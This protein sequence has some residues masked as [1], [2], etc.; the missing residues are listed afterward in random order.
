MADTVTLSG[1]GYPDVNGLYSYSYE[2]DGYPAYIK[3]DFFI[4][5]KT[6]NGPYSFTPNYYIGVIITTDDG[7]AIPVVRY[8]YRNDTIDFSGTWVALTTQASGE[9]QVGTATEDDF[10]SESSSL[11]VIT[12]STSS[13]SSSSFIY[14]SSS[15]SP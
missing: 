10:S 2:N 1:F 11:D 4:E 13:S 7:T 5:Y 9:Q 8:L 6:Q 15:S 14:S 12:S 3:G